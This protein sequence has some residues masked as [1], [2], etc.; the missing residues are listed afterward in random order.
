[1]IKLENKNCHMILT[2]KQRKS[3]HLHPEQLLN[4]NILL[5]KKNYF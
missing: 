2:E 5:E 1:M 4:M 3:Q